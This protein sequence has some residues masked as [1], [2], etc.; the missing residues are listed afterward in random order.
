MAEVIVTIRV[1]IVDERGRTT[2]VVERCMS[3][4]SGGGNPLYH[5][6]RYRATLGR[7]HVE[8]DKALAVMHG[9]IA[10]AVMHGDIEQV[11]SRG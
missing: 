1:E 2:D 6:A 3:D 11:K 7:L 8:V 10:L 9:D 5:V 4:D